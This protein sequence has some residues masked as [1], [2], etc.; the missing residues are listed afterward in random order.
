VPQFP[1][2]QGAVHSGQAL[3]WPTWTAG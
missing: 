2:V 3:A 1:K